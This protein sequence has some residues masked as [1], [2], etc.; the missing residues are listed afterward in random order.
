MVR[1]VIDTNVLVSALIHDGKPRELVLELF[2][3]HTVIL[4]RQMLAELA[5][6]RERPI[7]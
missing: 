5:H 4:S 7:T 3:R 1:A 6:M 2:D